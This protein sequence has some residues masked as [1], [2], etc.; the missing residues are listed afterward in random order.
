MTD[1]ARQRGIDDSEIAWI[2]GVHQRLEPSSSGRVDR[3]EPPPPA[4]VDR[5]R[6]LPFDIFLNRGHGALRL[7][8][9]GPFDE[10]AFFQRRDV[11]ARHDIEYLSAL[12]PRSAGKER[13][14]PYGVLRL[15]PHGARR[16]PSLAVAVDFWRALRARGLRAVPGAKVAIRQRF[17]VFCPHQSPEGGRNRVNVAACTGVFEREGQRPLPHAELVELVRGLE[18]EYRIA[19]LEGAMARPRSGE[20]LHRYYLDAS[21]RAYLVRDHWQAGRTLYTLEPTAGDARGLII[22]ASRAADDVGPA[23]A[24]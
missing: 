2:S 8:A 15:R 23:P 5:G 22:Y 24:T 11:G 14:Q 16:L 20:V 17:S 1:A 12:D 18:P 4:R 19:W 3:P 13:Y 21:L 10:L 9:A 7:F 6:L